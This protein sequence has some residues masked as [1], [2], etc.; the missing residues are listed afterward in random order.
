MEIKK[1]LGVRIK[2]TVI[3]AMSTMLLSVMLILSFMLNE[4]YAATSGKTGTTKISVSTKANWSYP[5][6]S[7]ITLKQNKQTVSYRRTLNA[8]KTG[9]KTGY[10]GC[11]T[12]TI[13]NQTNNKK[14]T[15]YWNGGQTC[16]IN[17]SANKDYVIT[18]TYNMS[19]TYLKQLSVVPCLNTM[20][21]ATTP[22]WNVSS[23][24]KVKS[25]K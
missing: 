2:K 4:A 3:C 23:T 22:S 5:G 12:I 7:S 25:Y 8:S 18:V 16:K 1:G 19:K 6:S 20:K 24:W 21:S 15:Q 11:Y 13:Y 14:T 9:S 17:L 10:Y